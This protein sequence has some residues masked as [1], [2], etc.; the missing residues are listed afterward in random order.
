[1]KHLL[2]KLRG[3][4]YILGYSYNFDLFNNPGPETL[5]QVQEIEEEFLIK[6]MPED[7]DPSALYLDEI[8][9]VFK[10]ILKET[11]KQRDALE[12]ELLSYLE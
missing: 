6:V 11:V 10:N 9:D 3:L 4:N 12:L 7:L 2:I 1:M 8:N 5:R